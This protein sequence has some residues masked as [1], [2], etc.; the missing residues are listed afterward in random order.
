[1]LI[2]DKME[3]VGCEIPIGNVE[4]TYK[5]I[6]EAED[7]FKS[8]GEFGLLPRAE[9]GFLVM[10]ITKN[11]VVEA[12]NRIK[13]NTTAGPDKVQVEALKVWDADCSS[14]SHT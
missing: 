2:L 5:G 10:P 12:R 7:G 13:V 1:M 6:W 8:L 14:V 11:E 4:A 3:E 9:N